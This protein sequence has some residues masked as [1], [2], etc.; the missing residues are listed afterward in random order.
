MFPEFNDYA[1]PVFVKEEFIL[2]AMPQGS[3]AYSTAIHFIV[4]SPSENTLK[5]SYFF[6][7]AQYAHSLLATYKT[8][9]F[10]TSAKIILTS[11]K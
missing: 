11:L 4:Q 8:V 6:T 5:D 10:L 3:S 2:N 1:K 9:I 7:V